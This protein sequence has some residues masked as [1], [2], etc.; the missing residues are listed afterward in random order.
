MESQGLDPDV[1]LA[2]GLIDDDGNLIVPRYKVLAKQ[3]GRL[4]EAL[5]RG[6][7]HVR[8][9]GQ[10]D[11][12]RINYHLQ[13]FVN[14]LVAAS[15]PEE[16][17]QQ[18]T[19]IVMDDT[20]ADSWAAW[21]RTSYEKDAEKND[22][23]VE[24]GRESPDDPDAAD[25][26]QAKIDD[27]DVVNPAQENAHKKMAKKRKEH[28]ENAISMGLNIGPDGRVLYTKDPDVRA[29]YKSANSEG[30]AGVYKGYVVRIA[31]AC[32]TVNFFGNLDP[33]PDPGDDRSILD[34]VTSYITALIV[35]SAGTNPGP[36]GVQLVEQSRQIAPNITDATADRGFTMKP[37][38][39]LDLHK[40]GIN[41][42]MDYPKTVVEKAELVMLAD[43]HDVYIH[44]G[45]ILPADIAPE[46]LTPPEF[47]KPRRKTQRKK[48]YTDRAN[49]FRY[50]LKQKRPGGSMQFRTPSHAGRVTNTPATI[51]EGSYDAPMVNIAQ[52]RNT[53]IADAER[54]NHS[55]RLP[56][57][58]PAWHTAYHSAR[59]TV[60]S[61]ISTIKEDG[62]LKHG[63]CKAMGLAANTLAAL[64]RIVI[65]NLAK[66]EENK[67]KEEDD[68]NGDGCTRPPADPSGSTPRSAR[69]PSEPSPRPA[70][71]SHKS[72]TPPRAPP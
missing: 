54:L 63:T 34:P 70:V 71:R 59:N 39:L 40:Q 29:G 14:L 26:A 28:I 8:N 37:G 45:T 66:T 13:W 69:N 10:P 61:A 16:V 17:R 64:A 51:A 44:C 18:I 6:W 68:S 60:E 42:F 56:Y 67:P 23:Y 36:A 55:Q 35:D 3:I 27:A 20:N 7:T 57:Y 11:E 2:V 65:V 19:H 58:T 1:A 15:V 22:P 41:V 25:P 12:E 38:F 31:V 33:Y 5:L 21:I 52:S 50:S 48:W 43:G 24:Y 72:E 30:P 49:T 4:E 62:A 53:V 46:L 32:A 47:D 9:E